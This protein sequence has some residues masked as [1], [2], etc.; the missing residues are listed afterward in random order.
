[1]LPQGISVVILEFFLAAEDEQ[2][3]RVVQRLRGVDP[4]ETTGADVD[5]HLSLARKRFRHRFHGQVPAK[6]LGASGVLTED[7][8]PNVRVQPVGADHEVEPAWRRLFEGHLGVG[9]DG[10]DRVAE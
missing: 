4:R 5:D 7:Q 6:E 9:G 8:A 1:L 3:P 2:C 10:C